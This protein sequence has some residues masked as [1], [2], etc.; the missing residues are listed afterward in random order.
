MKYIIDD[1]SKFSEKGIE[2]EAKSPLEAVKKAYPDKKIS[3][4]YGNSANIAV[5]GR[6]NYRYGTGYRIYLYKI[7]TA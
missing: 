4:E 7:E 2:I 1:I 5:K 6:F 3:R